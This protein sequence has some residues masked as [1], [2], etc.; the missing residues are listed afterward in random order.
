ML[1]AHLRGSL[2]NVSEISAE[3]Q[4]DYLDEDI[5]SQTFLGFFGG[6]G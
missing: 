2:E 1:K 4:K 5:L 6:R 3:A